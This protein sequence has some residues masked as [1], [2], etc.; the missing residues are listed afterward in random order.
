MG[1]APSGYEV[2]AAAAEEEGNWSDLEEEFFETAHRGFAHP[3]PIQGKWTI[4]GI[5]LPA[6]VLEKV[7]HGN[8]ER[9]LGLSPTPLPDAGAEPAR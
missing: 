7:Y 8:A 3:T 5:D 6:D 9:L 1:A 2:G 4:D